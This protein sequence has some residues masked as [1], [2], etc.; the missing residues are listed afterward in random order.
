MSDLKV[1][2]A[3]GLTGLMHYINELY[4]FKLKKTILLSPVV[5]IY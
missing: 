5:D 1:I 2:T 3:G 4:A